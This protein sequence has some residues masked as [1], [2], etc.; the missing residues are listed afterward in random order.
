MTLDVT[1]LGT[2]VWA[3]LWQVTAAIGLAAVATRLCCRARPHL[4]HLLWLVVLVKCW[5]PPVWSSP[6]GVFSWAQTRRPPV[7]DGAGSRRRVDFA[8][9]ALKHGVAPDQSADA[10]APRQAAPPSS[11][12]ADNDSDSFMQSSGSRLAWLLFAAW[13]GGAALVSGL[14]I[15]R[16]GR[17]RRRARAS[18]LQTPPHVESLLAEIAEKIGLRRVPRAIVTALPI[19]PAVYGLWRPT[20]VVPDFIVAGGESEQLRVVVAHEL[21]HVRRGDVAVGLFQW[22]TQV[23]WWFHPLVWWTGRE[24][25]R[26]RESCCDEEVVAALRCEAA[27]YAQSLLDVLK[28]RRRWSGSPAWV[29]MRPVDITRRRLAHIVER[30]AASQARTPRAY[31]LFAGVALLALAPGGELRLRAQV[32]AND[33]RH[34]SAAGP[35]SDAAE[36]E[37]SDRSPV[38]V[39][40]NDEPPAKD[41]SGDKPA[42]RKRSTEDMAEIRRAIDRGVAYLKAQQDDDGSWDD[43]P[44]YVGGITALCTLALLESGLAPD[45]DDVQRALAYLRDLKPETTYAASLTT[46]VLCAAEPHRDQKLI[47]RYATWL[48]DGQKQAGPLAGAWGYPQAEGD[49]SNSGFA[50]MALYEADRAGVQVGKDVWRRALNYWTNTQTANGAWGYKPV[51]PASGSMTCQGMAC[52]AAACE[53]LDERQPNQAGPRAVQK[54]SQWL[55]SHFSVVSNPGGAGSRGWLLYY[56]HAL[57]RAGQLTRQQTF[58][59]HDWFAEGAKSLISQQTVPDGYWQGAGHA[60]NNPR[61]ATSLALLFLTHENDLAR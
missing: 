10:G 12:P 19:G 46:M 28:T 37:P 43:P 26:Q 50:L 31:W 41:Q 57:R 51:A 30:G 18:A 53:V 59:D 47:Q 22:L 40:S 17:W 38:A 48:A 16:G 5:I 3:Q 42:D 13:L 27:Q 14:T 55:G 23:A 1:S 34:D 33:E 35:S 15:I 36:T 6:T 61:I 21:A 20:L 56:L 44:G 32:A 24:L 58:G 9:P 25:V 7:A 60:E 54:A 52:L 4:A 29:G 39:P 49:N 11:P 8:M 45:D 2:L